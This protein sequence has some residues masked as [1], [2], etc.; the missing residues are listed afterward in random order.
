MGECRAPGGDRLVDVPGGAFRMGAVGEGSYPADGE[1]PI[2]V[3]ELAPFRIAATAVTR[4]RVPSWKTPISHAAAPKLISRHINNHAH[5]SVLPNNHGDSTT[6][7]N[8]LHLATLCKR[9]VILPRCS[10]RQRFMLDF[11][12]AR[13][14][15]PSPE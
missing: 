13:V 5:G 15:L 10:G 7:S 4:W 3:V 1:G 11:V 8:T 2:H 12:S 6:A 14:S 9:R